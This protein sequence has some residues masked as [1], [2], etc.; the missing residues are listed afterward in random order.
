MNPAL[1]FLQWGEGFFTPVGPWRYLANTHEFAMPVELKPFEPQRIAVNPRLGSLPIQGFRS[2]DGT[3]AETFE[4]TFH[5]RR[6]MD[7]TE[8]PEP[9]VVSI[10]P[11][12]GSLVGR[13]APIKITFDQPMSPHH[14]HGIARKAPENDPV[15][16]TCFHLR[17]I[18]DQ[19]QFVIPVALPPNWSGTLEL[20][21]FRSRS[22]R[23]AMPVSISYSTGLKPFSDEHLE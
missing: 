10:E 18:E 1:T 9:Q 4:W 16:Q 22:R 7:D 12:P 19:N 6:D 11:P 23:H 5:T 20:H 3:L 8:A 14:F 13:I 15:G 2:V 17:Y 21:G